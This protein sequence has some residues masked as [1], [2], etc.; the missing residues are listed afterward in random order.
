[1]KITGIYSINNQVILKRFYK[2]G[3][4]ELSNY[5]FFLPEMP[6]DEEV[7]K[8]KNE[9]FLK[10]DLLDIS[11]DGL[12][13]IHQYFV[14]DNLNSY[15]AWIKNEKELYYV[16]ISYKTKSFGEVV[17]KKTS[18]KPNCFDKIEVIDKDFVKTKKDVFYLG[19]KIV[20]ADAVSFQRTICASFY[21]DENRVYSFSNFGI[22]FIEKQ[23]KLT[24]FFVPK[25]SC[26]ASQNVIYSLDNWTDKIKQVSGDFTGSIFYKELEIIISLLYPE[27]SEKECIDWQEKVG[28]LKNYENIFQTIFPD[29]DA[30]WNEKLSK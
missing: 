11:G 4:H 3:F 21:E 29:A 1:M 5:L 8:I 19:K 6:P 17:V 14:E 27:L 25:C 9:V 30:K 23:R 18:S 22:H 15:C 2:R 26:F 20:G 7:E 10:E 16:S 24:Y 12:E 13:V 28:V